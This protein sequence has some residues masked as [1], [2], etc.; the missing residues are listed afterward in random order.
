MRK[1]TYRQF[2]KRLRQAAGAP[3][4][5]DFMIKLTPKVGYARR[6]ERGGYMRYII[7]P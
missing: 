7:I 1:L 6:P 5:P 2:C 3:A 4:P